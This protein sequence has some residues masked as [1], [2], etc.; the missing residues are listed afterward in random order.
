MNVDEFSSKWGAAE[1]ITGTFE[2]R[3]ASTECPGMML[4]I[5]V[6]RDQL[7]GDLE[8]SLRDYLDRDELSVMTEETARG[9][10]DDPGD[11]EP[12]YIAIVSPGTMQ[13]LNR[14]RFRE[15]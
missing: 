4:A 3:E 6:V 15:A 8:A 10:I 7:T 5:L 1:G 12:P 2:R 9:F 14:I 13:V 11:M